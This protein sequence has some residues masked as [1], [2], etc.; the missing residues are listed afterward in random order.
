MLVGSSPPSSAREARLESLRAAIG[1]TRALGGSLWLPQ[2]LQSSRGLVDVAAI[3]RIVPLASEAEFLDAATRGTLCVVPAYS[4]SYGTDTSLRSPASSSA[5]IVECTGCRCWDSL[6]PALAEAATGQAL[7]A[8]RPLRS[9][10]EVRSAFA[11]QHSDD[12]TGSVLLLPQLPGSLL[13]ASATVMSVEHRCA[14]ERALATPCY[15]MRHVALALAQA[16]LRDVKCAKNH[17]L[18]LAANAAMGACSTEQESEGVITPEVH[19]VIVIDA[20][21]SVEVDCQ[22]LARRAA[23]AA[24]SLLHAQPSS[25][26]IPTVLIIDA[27]LMNG[28]GDV[29]E[30][31]GSAFDAVARSLEALLL[32][33]SV[34]A[35]RLLPTPSAAQAMGEVVAAPAAAEVAVR[36]APA[37]DGEP[38]GALALSM[39]CRWLCAAA[40]LL[41]L[42]P[43]DVAPIGLVTARQALGRPVD[44]A[45]TPSA[46]LPDEVRRYLHAS[47]ET[48]AAA[49]AAAAPPTNCAEPRSDSLLSLI[50]SKLDIGLRDR[51]L[52]H[53]PHAAAI[54]AA[55]Q[56][57]GAQPSALQLY[58]EFIA[59]TTP[60]LRRLSFAPPPLATAAR[61]AVIVEPRASEAIAAR[62][63][64]VI[65]NV[66]ALLNAG[67]DA[68]GWA[69]QFFHGVS[70]QRRVAAHFDEAE[71]ACVSCVDLG[72]DNLRS[73]QEYSQLLTSHWFWDQVGAET[74]LIFQED[75]MLCGPTIAPFVESC[76]YIGAPWDPSD[77]WVRGKAWLAAVGGNGGLSLRRRSRAIA[78]LDAGSWQRG[79]WEDAFFVERHQQLGHAVASS[80]TARAFVI[81]RP[82]RDMQGNSA[83]T[84]QPCGLHKVYNYLA[85]ESLSRILEK[86]E[87]AYGELE[88]AQPQAGRRGGGRA[89]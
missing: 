5:T 46:E 73:S 14:L 45:Y 70:N 28:A 29:L 19:L 61:V 1:I 10:A 40:P 38:L 2:W 57:L 18:T 26:A 48:S 67:G 11:S 15:A 55:S 64:Y 27:A 87:Q 89:I 3:S 22:S 58:E 44:H 65:R 74:V 13:S 71:W 82:L 9:R 42:P 25:S 66:G 43:I 60:A 53:H 17:W 78:C 59:R 79:Q 84:A 80:A 88:L 33:A 75:A 47:E 52:G 35:R 54:A 32:E 68:G 37:V 36:G 31:S 20:A 7:T 4:L 41:L 30:G 63:A 8:T 62:T 81:E 72:V 56:R 49:V 50:D 23:D 21:A 83:E 34:H 77:A 24:Q 86:V 12:T 76:D 85:A 16:T 6:Q 69:I 51:I 39:A